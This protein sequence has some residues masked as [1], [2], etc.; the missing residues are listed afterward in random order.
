LKQRKTK[1]EVLEKNQLDKLKSE[2]DLLEELE[3]LEI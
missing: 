1:G 2:D 3:K